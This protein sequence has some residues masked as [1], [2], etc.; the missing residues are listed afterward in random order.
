MKFGSFPLHF[1]NL[2]SFIFSSAAEQERHPSSVSYGHDFLIISGWNIVVYVPSLSNTIIR[3]CTP[4][5]FAAIPRQL[6]LLAIN[7]SSKS[8]ATCKSSFVA[9]SD[10]TPRKIGSCVTYLIIMSLNY[11]LQEF[12]ICRAELVIRNLA[13]HD[14]FDVVV[15][16]LLWS[17]IGNGSIEQCQM[18]RQV[19][20]FVDYVHKNISN[21]QRYCKFFLAFTNECLLLS[22]S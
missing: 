17:T 8:C 1:Y 6:S 9:T 22:L 14:P 15:L 19:R 21:R 20:I 5:T 3:L 7:V 4:I 13:R 11:I 2:I 10:L 16:Q 18:Y 12:F